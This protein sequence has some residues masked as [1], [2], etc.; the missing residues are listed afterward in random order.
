MCGFLLENS[1]LVSIS[2]KRKTDS[3]GSASEKST[4]IVI[5]NSIYYCWFIN[6]YLEGY[7]MNNKTQAI[8]FLSFL[9]DSLNFKKG[10]VNLHDEICKKLFE[11]GFL[12]HDDKKN[13]LYWI[14]FFGLCA[15]KHTESLHWIPT[16][17]NDSSSLCD[18]RQLLEC[19]I[20]QHDGD[21]DSFMAPSSEIP[22]PGVDDCL[23]SKELDEFEKKFWDFSSGL[24]QYVAVSVPS[25]VL[26]YAPL[27][28][29]NLISLILGIAKRYLVLFDTENKRAIILKSIVAC[30]EG[31]IP[32]TLL[33]VPK[34]R[35]ECGVYTF[36]DEFRE[37]KRNAIIQ[38]I[39]LS[40]M[41]CSGQTMV[42]YDQYKNKFQLSVID[43][44]VIFIDSCNKKGAFWWD[45]YEHGCPDLVNSEFYKTIYSLNI[46]SRYKNIL[47]GSDKKDFRIEYFSFEVSRF[48]DSLKPSH[49]SILYN[50][51]D[52]D[53]EDDDFTG[54]EIFKNTLLSFTHPVDYSFVFDDGKTWKDYNL[55]F[56]T[57]EY[58]RDIEN[59]SKE[60]ILDV[61]DKYNFFGDNE[62][63]T[64][65]KILIELLRKQ[66][67]SVLNK[68]EFD[69][70]Y[71]YLENGVYEWFHFYYSRSK[72]RMAIKRD[73]QEYY[74]VYRE[75]VQNKMDVIFDRFLTQT[76]KNDLPEEELRKYVLHYFAAAD[77][78]A[79]ER[80][81][82]LFNREK[83][84]DM[85][86]HNKKLVCQIASSQMLYEDFIKNRN[87]YEKIQGDYTNLVCGFIKAVER[88]LKEIWLHD[89]KL[90]GCGIILPSIK[91]IKRDDGKKNPVF[92]RSGVDADDLICFT[93]TEK[94]A[95]ITLSPLASA[96]SYA[97]RRGV[98]MGITRNKYGNPIYI[99][100]CELEN[101]FIN[102]VRNGHFHIHM[103]ETLEDAENKYMQ[104]SYYFRR[105]IDDINYT[106][107]C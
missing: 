44:P 106:L 31:L 105:C 6:R 45:I 2:M 23:S 5:W 32:D 91:G 3:N 77:D 57:D 10:F 43:F 89:P 49:L 69:R 63:N 1:S 15:G 12:F 16:W 84:Y 58:K 81:I 14:K 62:F 30:I 98:F 50:L 96:I 70:Q 36:K 97:I 51:L 103:I 73:Y 18:G 55:V 25:S 72:I 13:N 68:E 74:S 28:T 24:G 102:K 88:F 75:F 101:E 99:P 46:Q 66:Y 80:G 56:F 52:S 7:Y 4:V 83:E 90:K 78:I 61:L 41:F 35:K 34:L 39:S 100:N 20:P 92:G 93:D 9:T 94:T 95:N 67:S 29:R 48:L 33:D 26:D 21:E 47:L 79:K 42:F 53:V 87:K 59:L 107:P 27:M 19:R 71:N 60:T 38:C 17:G 22:F 65:L 76:I 86:K 64:Q 8:S 82:K 11:T 40:V 54:F 85:I 104:C 37:I